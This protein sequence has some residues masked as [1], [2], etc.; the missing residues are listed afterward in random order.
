MAVSHVKSNSILDFTGT[1]TV[2]NSQGSTTTANATDLVR[3]VDWNSAHNQFYTLS[4]NTNNASTASGTNVVLQGVGGVTLIGST[5]TIGISAAVP[6]TLSR[7]IYPA[8]WAS[9]NTSGATNN[10]VSV[11]YVQMPGQLSASNMRVLYSV[12]A[13]THTS[14]STNTYG[15]SVEAAVYTL[16]GSTLSQ[17]S[18]GSQSYSGT[19]STNSTAS[20]AGV[21]ELTVPL[22]VNMPPGDY[23]V[24]L[25][26]STSSSNASMGFSIYQGANM[27]T[28]ALNPQSFGAATNTS[29]L[30]F[31][32]HGIYS[33]TSGTLPASMNITEVLGSGTQGSRANFFFEMRNSTIYA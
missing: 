5:N 24:A 13:N 29:R 16:N 28:V 26:M 21:R 31:P 32:G 22:N 9:V 7:Y 14:A 17:A 23:W 15:I 30:L 20:V 33:A 6:G 1:V 12:S 4:G 25:R 11:N 8:E 27:G 2:L 10:S 3:P 18:S 19:W